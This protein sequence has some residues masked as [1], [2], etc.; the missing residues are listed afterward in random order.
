M[1]TCTYA[2]TQ[3]CKHS[4]A[5]RYVRTLHML[6]PTPIRTMTHAHTHTQISIYI[7]DKKKTKEKYKK[8]SAK[9]QK[10]KTMKN[11]NQTYETR[12]RI[13]G[14]MPPR[15]PRLA[16]G[17]HKS[18][19]VSATS[20]HRYSPLLPAEVMRPGASGPL[21]QMPRAQRTLAMRRRY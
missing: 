20:H 11:K 12:E 6:T 1:C 8:T 7:L 19:R 10:Q 14:T 13:R 2:R 21:R 18:P 17:H 5:S 16:T 3:D 15:S 4:S 9:K